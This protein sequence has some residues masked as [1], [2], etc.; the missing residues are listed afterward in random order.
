MSTKHP[1][2]PVQIVGW[3]IWGLETL[4]IIGSVGVTSMTGSLFDHYS[5]MGSGMMGGSNMMS[6]GH[7]LIGLG[8]IWLIWRVGLQILA[9]FGIWHLHDHNADTWPIILIVTGV[10]G[11]WLYLI[12]GIWGLIY[13]GQ[14]RNQTNRNVQDRRKVN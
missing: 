11:G 1:Q 12:P 8:S 2:S 14:Q 13:N 9:L 10:L 3:V 4:V 7:W 5:M 6:S